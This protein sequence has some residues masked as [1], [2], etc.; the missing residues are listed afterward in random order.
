MTVKEYLQT[1]KKVSLKYLAEEMWPTNKSA[2]TYLTKKLR[3]QRPWTETDEELARKALHKL[4]IEL[5]DL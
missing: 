3:G 2:D 4:G 5:K 1:T